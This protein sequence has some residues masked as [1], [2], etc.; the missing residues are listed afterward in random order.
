M[1]LILASQNSHKVYELRNHLKQI[2][3]H[4]TVLS[5]F[6][7]PNYKSLNAKFGTFA[8]NA[9][10]KA[11]D[12]AKTL[13]RVCLADDSG[14]VI[15][16][17]GKEE[18]SLS[19]RYESD[20]GSQVLATKKLLEDMASFRDIERQ[21]YLECCLAIATPQE[22]VKCAT[23]RT[24]GY[25]SEEERGKLTF[26]FDT[27]FIKHDYNKTLGELA[28]SIRTRISHR[29]KALEKLSGTIEQLLKA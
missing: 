15:P 1:E 4:I 23:Q 11:L 8:E 16:V 12:A 21:A 17:L 3:P 26:E 13:G 25:L 28:P 14:I 29:R 5:L 2:A 27:I 19:R 10:A 6:D 20:D 18:N 9:K 22:Y 7:F 24:E